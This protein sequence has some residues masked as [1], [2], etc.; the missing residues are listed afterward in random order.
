MEPHLPVPY[1]K[2]NKIVKEYRKPFTDSIGNKSTEVYVD[3]LDKKGQVQ[4][5]YLLR[6]ERRSGN[7]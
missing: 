7:S 5:G 3:F 1:R 4:E 2:G 6:V